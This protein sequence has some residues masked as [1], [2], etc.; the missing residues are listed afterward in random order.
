MST[1]MHFRV[2]LPFARDH[3]VRPCRSGFRPAV[4]ICAATLIYG[5][6]AH[7]DL[8][9][10]TQSNRER[11]TTYVGMYNELADRRRKVIYTEHPVSARHGVI[12]EFVHVSD[13]SAAFAR[14]DLVV[15]APMPIVVRRSY[16]SSR[17][18]SRLFGASGWR[19]TIDESI[20][21]ESDGGYLYRYGN[22]T[23]IAFDQE[24]R[25]AHELD[26]FLSE[27]VEFD[28][29]RGNL[30]TIRTRTDLTKHFRKKGEEFRLTRVADA[31]GNTQ[32]FHYDSGRLVGITSDESA[33][34]SL[35]YDNA[36]RL[37]AV[38]DSTGRELTYSY[39]DQGR[40]SAAR[41]IRG[42]S[43][44]FAYSG[45]GNLTQSM[46][47]NG[48]ADLEFSYDAQGRVETLVRNGIVTRYGYDDGV[49]TATD[50]IGRLTRF[51]ADARGLTQRVVNAAGS[52][53]SVQFS[54]SGLPKSIR[55]NGDAIA[56]FEYHDDLPGAPRI[57]S[58]FTHESTHRL[59]TDEQGRVVEVKAADE[60]SAS[61]TVQY[62]AGL[63]PTQVDL[64]TGSTRRVKYDD[65]GHVSYYAPGAGE[66]VMLRRS[67][68][69][70][71]LHK[72][73]RP[74][75][76]LSFNAYGQLQQVEPR[77]GDS[78]E[79]DYDS[80]G[81]RQ[82]TATSTG[83]RVDYVYDATG[84]LMSTALTGTTGDT[85]RF[86]YGLSPH[87][88]L[89]FISSGKP[90]NDATFEYNNFGLP[91]KTSATEI[92]GLSFAHDAVGRLRELP[93]EIS[94]SVFHPM[95]IPQVPRRMF[96]PDSTVT[97]CLKARFSI[98]RS[99][100]RRHIARNARAP[101]ETTKT[102][103]RSMAAKFGLLKARN[104]NGM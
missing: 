26:A 30:I 83:E 100:Q 60:M 21:R 95:A 71:R 68:R 53:T 33:S 31:F 38:S 80:A 102:S 57:V 24:G 46:T 96:H 98:T 92:I 47:P 2:S 29:P 99:A 103:T 37:A 43:W 93:V 85:E 19:L 15:D 9:V 12:H 94:G 39:D 4:A 40:L 69:T 74:S 58:I 81:F 28:R 78:A 90:E 84:N 64:A 7:A 52:D 13:G 51:V 97:C 54:S 23:T 1:S 8:T 42:Q 76:T 41:D 101:R 35:R 49:T 48:I 72:K 70:I 6:S 89:E 88:R 61:Y 79:F 86:V 5:I 14:T 67:G 34:I 63:A 3:R 82:S 27:V 25:F 44:T 87:N 32:Q 36:S 65:R 20:V 17:N 50:S 55:R 75:A 77:Q 66:P 104:S 22:G 18:V 59:R 16:N 73:G 56:H 62:A 11:L 10:D 91:L 45:D